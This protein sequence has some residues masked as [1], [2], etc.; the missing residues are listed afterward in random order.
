MTYF[1][2]LPGSGGSGPAHWQSRWEDANPAMGRFRPSSWDLPDF[3]DWL[4]ALEAGVIAAPEPPVLVAHS[5]SCLLIAHW[6]KISQRPVKA[7]LLVGVPDPA[8]AV[9]PGYGMAFAR[10]PQGKLR[11]AS[12]V[13]T[14]TNDPYGSQE[15]AE[16][17]ATQWGSRL[18][19]IGPF[20]HINAE[21][22]LSDWPEGLKLLDGLVCE[23]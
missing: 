9:F 2:I 12:L 6:Q 4:A 20:G 11:F 10:I 8:S 5:L 16:A 3:T 7:A 17:R 15:Y 19:V 13:V 1:I 18:A 23:A 22:G 21:S 14:S